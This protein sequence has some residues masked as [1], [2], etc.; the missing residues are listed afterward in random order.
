MNDADD[1]RQWGEL[2]AQARVQA[3]KDLPPAES[4]EQI[5]RALAEARGKLGGEDVQVHNVPF[6]PDK[7][8]LDATGQAQE[9]AAPAGCASGL[10]EQQQRVS[11]EDWGRKVHS[12]SEA[13][14]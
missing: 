10:S 9:A 12:A 3:E 11:G 4:R 14:T 2:E 13:V 1:S 6:H 8:G 7:W 5:K